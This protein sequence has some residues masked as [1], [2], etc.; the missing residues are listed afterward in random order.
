L[1]GDLQEKSEAD[2][3]LSGTTNPQVIGVESQQ[4][5][6]RQLLESAVNTV[7][8]VKRL[9][10]NF[11]QLKE[12][13]DN[14]GR[15]LANAFA[16]NET[17]R[18]Q[19]NDA[20]D[21]NDQLSKTV[22]TLT[23]QMESIAARC[24]EAVTMLRSQLDKRAHT[25]QTGLPSA[26]NRSPV[27]PAV[28]RSTLSAPAQLTD[29][30]SAGNERAQPSTFEAGSNSIDEA[31]RVVHVFTQYLTQSTTADIHKSKSA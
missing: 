13:R 21:H 31:S 6:R 23:D 28:I 9:V 27:V 22:A 25:V 14:F 12:E 19:V 30:P 17:L 15:Q 4:D 24:I 18:E 11:D 5:D 8:A 3:E 16:E 20:N 10:A 2:M 26:D 7:A 1:N 29:S